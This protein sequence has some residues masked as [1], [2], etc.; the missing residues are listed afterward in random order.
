MLSGY[1]TWPELDHAD[2]WLVFP[3][4]TGPRL[5]IDETAM[6]NGELRTVVTNRD[7]H[8][9]DCCLVA[10]VRGVRSEDVVKALKRIPE[11]LL[12]SVEEVTPGLSD[13]MWNSIF[14]I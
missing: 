7:R 6:S 4:N 12:E 3:E 5:A 13:S 14:S 2:D 9:R 11:E 10:I 1:R 8:G